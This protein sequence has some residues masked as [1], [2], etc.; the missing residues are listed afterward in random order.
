MAA[1]V[2]SSSNNGLGVGMS[3]DALARQL[4]QFMLQCKLNSFAFAGGRAVG[5]FPAAAFFNH[6]CDANAEVVS[7]SDNGHPE[8]VVATG[9]MI[10]ALKPISIGDEITLNYVSE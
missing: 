8:G 2:C 3:Q 5:L 1:A 10:R 6:S 7:C 9:I 4:L